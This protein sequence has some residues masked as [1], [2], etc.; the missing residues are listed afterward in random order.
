MISGIAG[1]S[2]GWIIP[3]PF[4]LVAVVLGHIGLVQVKRTGE[5]G[6]TYAITGLILGYLGVLVSIVVIGLLAVW[7]GLLFFGGTGYMHDY[8]FYGG[9]MNP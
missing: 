2:I 1:L 8:G 4:S 3:V 6:R 7:F 9:M 5:E